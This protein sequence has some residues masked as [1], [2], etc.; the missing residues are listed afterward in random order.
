MPIY[1]YT[2]GAC[3]HAF[4]YLARTLSDTPDDCPQCGAEKPEKQ[5]ST[6]AVAVDAGTPEMPACAGGSCTPDSCA[7]GACPFG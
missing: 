7:S 3:G 6:F 4:E 2:C 5:L 1:D